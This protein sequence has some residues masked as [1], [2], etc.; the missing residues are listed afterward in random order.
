MDTL[1][2]GGGG[3]RMDTLST[4]GWMDAL[5]RSGDSVADP[6]HT[7]LTLLLN[8]DYILCWSTQCLAQICV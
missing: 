7:V 3:G 5:S 4:D 8:G 1:S 2:G 6:S